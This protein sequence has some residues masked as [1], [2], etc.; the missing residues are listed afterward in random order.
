[1]RIILSKITEHQTTAYAA[2]ELE[3][4]LKAIDPKLEIDKRT[5]DAFEPNADGVLWVGMN[6]IVAES[7]DDEILID[8]KNGAGIITGSSP[9]AVLIASYRF[10]YELGCRWIRPGDDG[11]II[12]R[13]SLTAENVNVSVSEKASYRHRAVCIEGSVN[14]EHV[15]NVINWLPKAGMNG[16]YMQFFV[17]LCFFERWYRH[18]WNPLREPE[19]IDGEAVEHMQKS[20]EAEIVKRDLLYHSTGHGWTCEPFG[21]HGTGWNA[22]TEEIPPETKQYFAE[23][24]GKRELW[25]N[26]ALNTNLCYSNAEVRDRITDSITQYCRNHTAV[27]YLHFWLADGTN[28]HC[29]CENCRKMRP[30]DFYVQM[31]NELDVKLTAAG[32]KT[33]IV[34]LLYYDLLWEPE[35]MRIENPDRFVL[36]FAPITRSYYNEFANID[37]SKKIEPAPY[38]RNRIKAPQSVE[39]NVMRLK[40]WQAQFDGDSFDFDYHLMW[41]HHKDIG[42]CQVARQLHNDMANLSKLGLNGMVSCQLQRASFPTGLPMYAMAKALWN[43]NSNYDDVSREYFE[44]SF[45]ENGTAVEKYLETLSALLAENFGDDFKSR[46]EKAKTTVQDFLGGYIEKN[47]DVN[48]SWKYLKYHADISLRTFDVILD[49]DDMPNDE[50]NARVYE[51]RRYLFSLEPELNAVFDTMKAYVSYYSKLRRE[52]KSE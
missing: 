49:S 5:Y 42:Y 38:E 22:C 8:V 46:V 2:D 31:L 19:P 17:P 51:L 52:E 32:I 15:Y 10:L 16:Y 43:K 26:V 40:N 35:V 4:C 29:E 34:F 20:L 47:A 48:A 33:K 45:G 37:G 39:E 12:P 27:D 14:Y 9:R 44:A 50:H 3:R 25:E 41:H 30:S 13:R 28:N 24:G 7:V 21:I 6:E 1:M 11:E 18:E 36:M 23:V